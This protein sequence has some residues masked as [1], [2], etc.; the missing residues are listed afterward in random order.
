MDLSG[1]TLWRSTM[2][3]LGKI[4]LP[5]IR[6]F[7]MRRK[8]PEAQ[9]RGI[10]AGAL[11]LQRRMCADHGE[12]AKNPSDHGAALSGIGSAGG[13]VDQLHGFG[14]EPDAMELDQQQPVVLLVA[15][16]IAGG[17]A[18]RVVHVVLSR[19]DQ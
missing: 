9:P 6:T 16:R 15:E 5:S 3:R 7:H 17:V 14:R 12:I 1:V 11:E 18:A 2:R 13:A 4:R 8:K 19:A 10:Q